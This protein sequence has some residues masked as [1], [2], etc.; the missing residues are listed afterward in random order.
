MKLYCTSLYPP[1]AKGSKKTDSP[2]VCPKRAL[3]AKS[4]NPR[5]ISRAASRPRATTNPVI[6]PK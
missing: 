3:L 1:S 5:A 6:Q 2:Q 4:R